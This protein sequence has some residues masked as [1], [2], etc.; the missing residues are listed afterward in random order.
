MTPAREA[1]ILDRLER[2][3]APTPRVV[4]ID[5]R[6]VETDVPALLETVLPGRPISRPNDRATF[7]DHLAA[8][9]SWIQAIPVDTIRDA[10]AIPYRRFYDPAALAPPSWA[11]DPAAWERAI[12]LAKRPASAV[13]SGFIHRDYHP[14]NVLWIGAR[15]DPQVGGV[16]DWTSASVGPFVIDIGHMRWNLAAFW[17]R[18][19]ADRFLAACRRLGLARDWSPEW[20]IRS[21]LDVLP[22]LRLGHDTGVSL[23]RT[24]QHIARALAELG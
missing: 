14:G 19:T 18:A 20:D 5:P 22:E 6:G 10:T 13:A 4:A 15:T 2:A 23:R 17:D 3:S 7:A 9:L 24:E 8:P 1:S 11:R 16:V 21:T 12:E